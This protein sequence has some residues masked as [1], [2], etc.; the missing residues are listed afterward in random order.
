MLEETKTPQLLRVNRPPLYS[1]RRAL[2]GARLLSARPAGAGA[3]AHSPAFVVQEWLDT[4]PH[5]GYF[6]TRVLDGF[7]TAASVDSLRDKPCR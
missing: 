7:I 4:G 5:G 1:H 6:T 2:R 3:G